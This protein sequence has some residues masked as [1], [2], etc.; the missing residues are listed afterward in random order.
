MLDKNGAPFPAKL[1]G[2]GHPWHGLVENG[3]LTLPNNQTI[4]YQQPDGGDTQ[5][6]AVPG[7]PA[8]TRTTEQQ[9]LDTA[10]G[11]Q[12]WNDAILS[13]EGRQ[14]YG[15]DMNGRWIYIDPNGGRWLVEAPDL[16]GGSIDLTAQLSAQVTLSK[17]GHIG[18]ADETYTLNVSVADLQQ[19][20]PVMSVRIPPQMNYGNPTTG[21]S[22]VE[23]ITATGDKAIVMLHL[24]YDQQIDK[25]AL[26]FLQLTLTGIPGDQ[27]TPV[28][29]SLT[30]LKSR[31]QTIGTYSRTTTDAAIRYNCLSHD[32]D[33]NAAV[34]GWVASSDPCSDPNLVGSGTVV[35]GKT[36]QST[37]TDEVSGRILAI[38]F[39]A[40]GAMEEL[41]LDVT[42]ASTDTHNLPTVT[43]SGTD[44][45]TFSGSSVITAE[46][47][48]YTLSIG[49]QSY[50]LSASF[51]NSTSISSWDNQ[52]GGSTSESSQ[53]NVEGYQETYSGSGSLPAS[54]IPTQWAWH[55]ASQLFFLF[56]EPFYADWYGFPGFAG[57]LYWF[58]VQRFSNHLY[59]LLTASD[60]N[61]TV[62]H[63]DPAENIYGPVFYP[64]GSDAGSVTKVG[65]HR[66]GSWNPR[67]GSIAKARDAPVCWV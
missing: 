8:V 29:A 15:M 58:K 63:P 23:S 42:V 13:G 2:F 6:V 11:W 9:A 47:A 24:D 21:D 28:Q 22:S 12:W 35:E 48:A 41:Q 32:S 27:T 10:N 53:L 17:F 26:G 57:N 64:G 44:T 33:G 31:A 62:W 38:W 46:T 55:G 39:D 51:D 37:T 25:R 20:S 43:P 54:P 1:T 19:S 3:Q 30:L 60:P 7:Q 4:T 61:D 45:Y 5:R 66:Y 40:S 56:D 50:T 34:S 14:L 52:N 67:D 36:G 59:G 18:G 65:S 16:T 49:G